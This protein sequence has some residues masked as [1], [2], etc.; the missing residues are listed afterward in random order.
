M[1]TELVVPRD[2]QVVEL[3]AVVVADES[4]RLLEVPRLELHRR[5]GGVTMRLLS[6]RHEALPEQAADGLAAEQ[7]QVPGTRGKAEQLLRIWRA[8]PL[9]I[10]GQLRAVEVVTDGS[11]TTRRLR[12]HSRQIW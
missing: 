1:L 8:Q 12:T 7:P 2:V 10:D 11:G 6:A 9:E 3:G 4:C 5:D